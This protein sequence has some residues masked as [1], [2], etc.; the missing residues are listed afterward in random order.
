MRI[1]AL[2]VVAVA[3][4]VLGGCGFSPPMK[5]YDPPR[6]QVAR[7]REE[8]FF[9]VKRYVAQNG[10]ELREQDARTGRITAW[11]VVTAVDGTRERNRWTFD[12]GEGSI[13]ARRRYELL[14]VSGAEA[15]W[16]SSSEVCDSYS[17][18]VERDVVELI[19]QSSASSADITGETMNSG[20]SL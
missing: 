14:V 9:Q 13:R 2:H 10:W 12:V 15:E 5:A 3:S 17:Y 11:E 16:I 18:S 20:G 6:V 19:A 8:L 1:T 4:I 7:H